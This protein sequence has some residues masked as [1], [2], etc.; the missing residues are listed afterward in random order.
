MCCTCSYLHRD[1]FKAIVPGAD[2]YILKYIL[3]NYNDEDCIKILKNV[4]LAMKGNK[5][6]KLLIME[7]VLDNDDGRNELLCRA[8]DIRMMVTFN[9]K[10][11]DKQEFEMLLETSGF[12]LINIFKSDTEVS[13]IEAKFIGN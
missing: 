3:H 6:A 7:C 10:E 1:M 2:C 9:A 13:I 11:R 12:E 5:A 8:M 4:A